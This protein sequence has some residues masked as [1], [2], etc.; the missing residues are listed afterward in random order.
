MSRYLVTGATGFLGAHL[1]RKLV[2]AGHEVVALARGN[3]SELGA[4]VTVRRGDVLEPASVKDAATGCEGVF[5]CAG[6]VSRDPADA[7][8]LYRVHVEGTKTTLDACKA[9][10]VTR[11]VVASTSGTVAVS[12]DP[13]HIANEND[14]TPIALVS[15]WPYYRAKLFAEKA[16]LERN[17]PGFA[18]VCVNPTLL[19]G[20]GDTRG[21]S[22]EDVRLFLEK[23]L[24]AVPP[25]GMSFVDARDAA[26]AMMLAMERGRP[27]ARYLVGAQN[28]TIRE[29]FA[30]LERVSGVKGPWLPMPR[31]PEVARIGAKAFERIGA[32]LGVSLPVDPVSV[33]MAQFYWY[34]DATLAEHELGW[35]ARDP[36]TTLVDTV[37]DL[38]ARGVVWPEARSGAQA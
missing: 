3:A 13:D 31:A 21:S 18:V 15:R 24:P 6:I 5:H 26:R 33:D 23:K 7:E 22:T 8:A 2:A 34:L 29:F 16:A 17:V 32:K 38:R 36:G 19:L 4:K 37:E 30:R 28:L 35:V 12:D 9:A 14:E 10:G 27:G 11:A 25:G 20:P 1:V